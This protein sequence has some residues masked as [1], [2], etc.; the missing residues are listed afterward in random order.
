[1]EIR[2]G[3][4][5]ASTHYQTCDVQPIEII[6]MYLPREQLIGYLR[7]NIIKYQLRYGHKDPT[8]KEAAKIEQYAKWLAVIENGGKINPWE[9]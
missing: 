5:L 4:A 6:Q 7:G 9:K 2:E 1:M 8:P 3:S